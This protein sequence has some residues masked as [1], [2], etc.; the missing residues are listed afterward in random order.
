[1][2]KFAYDV[3]NEAESSTNGNYLAA[4]ICRESACVVLCCFV[5]PDV[6]WTRFKHDKFFFW[7]HATKIFIVIVAV[8]TKPKLLNFMLCV[9]VL[10]VTRSGPDLAGGRPR[11]QLDL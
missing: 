6:V 4:N 1:V 2:V 11:A 10:S 7:Y 3:T 8:A 5:T 9:Q